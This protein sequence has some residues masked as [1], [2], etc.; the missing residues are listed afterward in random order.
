MLKAL[1]LAERADRYARHLPPLPAG[2]TVV[3][4][5]TEDDAIAHGPGAQALACWPM[6]NPVRLYA[7]APDLAW[8]QSLGAGV[9]GILTPEFAQGP[10][11]LTNSRGANAPP[12]AEH[13][14]ALMLAFA[15][16]LHRS[17]QLQAAA[18]W[19][20]QFGRLFEVAGLTLGV[21]GLGGIG[22]E[23]AR[24]A[25][26]LGMRVV[27]ARR[28]DPGGAGADPDVDALTTLD[29]LL[30]TADFVVLAVP[31]TAETQGLLGAG[32]LARMK[33]TA[34]LINV[35]RGQVVDEPAL[36]AAL[37]AGRLA[38]AGLDVFATEPL[39]AD[40]PL[41]SLPNVIITPH[42]AAASPRTME[43]TMALWAEN[44]RRFAAGEPLR[45]P[46][47][48]QRGY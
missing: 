11:R 10:L 43:R 47:D 18:R 32:A 3:P 24:R 14:L 48:K 1:L 4:C 31:L 40:S 29:H 34:Y 45:N 39:P 30:G 27:A 21:V 7:A 44:L 22:R 46:V 23:V 6:A 33:P 42:Q 8:V 38:G 12:I 28:T 2:I 9:E 25:R 35:S 19:E 26:A 13:V 36:A 20:R 17:V 16:G 41:W 37:Q 5:L 15:R